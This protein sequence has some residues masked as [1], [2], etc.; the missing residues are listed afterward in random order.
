MSRDPCIATRFDARNRWTSC[1]Q[2]CGQKVGNKKALFE[3]FWVAKEV[4][5]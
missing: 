1:G 4:D 2:F 3:R 5:S